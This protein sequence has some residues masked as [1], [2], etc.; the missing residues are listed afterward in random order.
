MRREYPARLRALLDEW[1][2]EKTSSFVELKG[3]SLRNWRM[4]CREAGVVDG[5]KWKQ[6]EIAAEYK[7]TIARV[8]KILETVRKRLGESVEGCA[9]M[10]SV[11]EYR[12]S[13]RRV[14]L[15]SQIVNASEVNALTSMFRENT[16]PSLFT[17]VPRSKVQVCLNETIYSVIFIAGDK[18]WRKVSAGRLGRDV[19][20]PYEYELSRD[21]RWLYGYK[22]WRNKRVVFPGY[23]IFWM[24]EDV[25]RIGTQASR[26]ACDMHCIR[27][28]YLVF[29]CE[30]SFWVMD[31]VEV[32]REEKRLVVR[33]K[34]AEYGNSAIQKKSDKLCSGGS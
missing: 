30:G 18:H 19:D 26:I 20:W 16:L 3:V 6:R 24:E 23:T 17:K 14:L 8:S 10:G 25:E 27:D 34:P 13:R 5:R 32:L 33:L 4:F 28:S 2:E 31:K 9:G 7:L 15:K 11:R 12:V 22:V 1:D 21:G 29:D